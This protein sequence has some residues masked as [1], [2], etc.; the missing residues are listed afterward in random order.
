[1]EG[2][3]L[4]NV[5]STTLTRFR[6][7]GSTLPKAAMVVPSALSVI[8]SKRI[9]YSREIYFRE[10]WHDMLRESDEN[11][12][13]SL[14]ST[15]TL[16]MIKPDG[17]AARAIRP[18]ICTLRA[19]GFEILAGAAVFLDRISMRELWRYEFNLATMQRMSAIDILLT[20]GPSL[21][22]LL[23]KTAPL[24]CRSA[25]DDLRIW[26]GP[27]RGHRDPSQLRSIIQALPGL[28][29]YIHCPDEPADV[30]RELG[31]LL[32]KTER[33]SMLRALFTNPDE[34]SVVRAH[35]LCE[36]LIAERDLRLGV[37]VD[38]ICA[39][40]ELLPTGS[41]KDLAVSILGNARIAGKC[42]WE[43]LFE[44]FDK[45]GVSYDDW[46][47]IMFAAWCTETDIPG[48]APIFKVP[49]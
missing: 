40:I 35:T 15:V 23:R 46:D 28:L 27:S 18:T 30:V 16:I 13:I 12:I 2:S 6:D 8:K 32:S 47:R 45:S 19:H 31:V 3:I 20:S 43:V 9:A 10:C 39:S 42:D 21:L 24:Y 36:S 48:I 41:T 1:M 38:H 17:V 7:M 14:L 34:E 4:M 26:K 11:N 25:A 37:V 29:N 22:L 44:I 5:E 33:R 49:H